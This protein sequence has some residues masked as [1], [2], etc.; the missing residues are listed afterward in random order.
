MQKT[1]TTAQQIHLNPNFVSKSELEK[2][3]VHIN[4]NFANRSLPPV[5]NAA[6]APPSKTPNIKR[7]HINPNFLDGKKTKAYQEAI[8]MAVETKIH[9]NPNYK[10]AKVSPTSPLEKE[11]IKTPALSVLSSATKSLFKKI[12]KRKWMR[13]SKATQVKRLCLLSRL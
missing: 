5:P 1:T 11:N 6:G 8:K 4:P 13:V 12:G 3:N 7:A 2:S 9:V 10:S